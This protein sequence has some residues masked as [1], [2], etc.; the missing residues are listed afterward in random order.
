[1]VELV[2]GNGA[3]SLRADS[4]IGA[5]PRD[6]ADIRAAR[7]GAWAPQDGVCRLGIGDDIPA[8]S[9]K[10]IPFYERSGGMRC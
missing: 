9:S 5:I 8:G 3:G 10:L 2:T 6:G 7:S 4:G 1:M